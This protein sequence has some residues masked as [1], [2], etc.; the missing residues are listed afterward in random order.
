MGSV[1]FTLNHAG[2]HRAIDVG[3]GGS[4]RSFERRNAIHVYVSRG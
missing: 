3:T 4:G 1:P 2:N